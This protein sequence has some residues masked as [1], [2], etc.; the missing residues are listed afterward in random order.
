[1][2]MASI[3]PA[4][5]VAIPSTSFSVHHHSNAAVVDINPLLI[6][7]VSSI[8]YSY[9]SIIFLGGARPTLLYCTFL[10]RESIPVANAHAISL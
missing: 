1:M 5:A 9:I 7:T 3:A 2:T 4:L 6:V 8:A 10:H